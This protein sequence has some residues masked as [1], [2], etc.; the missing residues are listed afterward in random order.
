MSV[1]G[2]IRSFMIYN[3]VVITRAMLANA[4]YVS[5]LELL[6]ATPQEKIPTD[7]L[8]S[9]SLFSLTIEILITTD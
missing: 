9:N 7:K 2:L 1:K 6:M 5:C 4:G 8:R 3:A